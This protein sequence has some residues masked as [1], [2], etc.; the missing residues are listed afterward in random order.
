MHSSIALQRI[1]RQIGPL[2]PTDPVRIAYE[3]IVATTDSPPISEE[4]LRSVLMSELGVIQPVPAAQCPP[5][6]SLHFQNIYDFV[7]WYAVH[8]QEFSDS[9]RTAL[10]T[11]LMTRNGIEAGCACRRASREHLAHA[12]FGEFW[13][14]NCKTDLLP[15]IARIAGASSVSIA[16]ICS[17]PSIA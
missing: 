7:S 17:Y 13:S 12:Y 1:K 3:A 4:E 11:L 9:Q 10:D 2:A 8:Q 16:N 6:D 14:H 15:T 5:V